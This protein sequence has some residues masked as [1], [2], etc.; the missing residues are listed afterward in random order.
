MRG[1]TCSLWQLFHILTV[2][3]GTHPE[4]LADTGE[5]SPWATRRGSCRG[6]CQVP[7]D[8]WRQFLV[9]C[10]RQ[11]VL[12]APEVPCG[13]GEA[14]SCPHHP[15]LT[16]YLRVGWGAGAAKPSPALAVGRGGDLARSHDWER[17]PRSLRWWQESGPRWLSLS[18]CPALSSGHSSW[19]RSPTL[20]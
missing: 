18:T 8:A 12:G 11:R 14:R 17:P 4:A 7:S 15:L 20:V 1:Y 13:R 9:L 10:A 16:R 6:A 5:L 3:A 19:L 2:E